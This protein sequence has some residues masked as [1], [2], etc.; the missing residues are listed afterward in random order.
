MFQSILNTLFGCSHSRTT[1]PLTPGS[2]GASQAGGSRTYVVCLD[3]G[4][5]F[6]YDWEEMRV[7]EPVAPHLPAAEAQPSFR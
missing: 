6:A 7:G 3:C 4:R 2:R 5:E 1:F